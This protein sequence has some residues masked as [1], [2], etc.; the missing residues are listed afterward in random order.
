MPATSCP[1]T[2]ADVNDGAAKKATHIADIHSPDYGKAVCPTC[3]QPLPRD[4]KPC[5]APHEERHDSGTVDG[6]M[7]YGG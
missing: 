1:S 6:D 3:K 5:A 7:R 4:G 2:A